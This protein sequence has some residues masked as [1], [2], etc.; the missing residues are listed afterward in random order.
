MR[1]NRWL[2]AMGGLLLVSCGYRFVNPERALGPDVEQIEIRPLE[3]RSNEPGLE[4]VLVDGLV[5][6]FSRRGQLK[7]VYGPPAGASGL[8]LGGVI[9][10]VQIR[11]ASFSSAG[12]ATELEIRMVVAFDLAGGSGAKP[13]WEN[14]EIVLTERYLASSDPGAEQAYKEQAFERIAMEL[15]GRVHDVLLQ[16]F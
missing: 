16:T 12:L 10:D 13:L 9:R 6:E 4:R 2:V 3:N 14:Q 11:P 5:E 15:A 7:P 8:S 1:P